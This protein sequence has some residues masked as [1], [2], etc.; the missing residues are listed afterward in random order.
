MNQHTP[1]NIKTIKQKYRDLSG[2][3]TRGT[4]TAVERSIKRKRI[5]SPNSRIMNK[6]RNLRIELDFFEEPENHN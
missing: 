1:S 2:T 3:K 4:G 6:S 5:V